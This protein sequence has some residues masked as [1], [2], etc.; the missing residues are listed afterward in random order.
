M[1]GRN[2][3]TTAYSNDSEVWTNAGELVLQRGSSSLAVDAV[4]IPFSN[5]LVFLHIAADVSTESAG[6]NF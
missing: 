1:T 2:T 4:D 6:S 5:F 3:W